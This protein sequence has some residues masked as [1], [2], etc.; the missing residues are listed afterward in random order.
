[1]FFCAPSIS[2]HTDDPLDILFALV[3]H[4]VSLLAAHTAAAPIGAHNRAAQQ[5]SLLACLHKTAYTNQ[6]RHTCYLPRVGKGV[7]EKA[8][9]SNNQSINQ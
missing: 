3:S 1:M 2:Q 4:I 6:V 5:V 9:V 8:Q 7:L